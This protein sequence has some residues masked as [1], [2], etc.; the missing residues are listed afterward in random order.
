[1][2]DCRALCRSPECISM[3]ALVGAAHCLPS[4][5]CY[6]AITITNSNIKTT[7]LPPPPP[8]PNTLKIISL[9]RNVQ[10]SNT[11]GIRENLSCSCKNSSDYDK[12]YQDIFLH[13]DSSPS[14]GLH[15]LCVLQSNLCSKG[16]YLY[17]YRLSPLLS[18]SLLS[19]A[20]LNQ[21]IAGRL[22][23]SPVE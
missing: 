22:P 17:Y 2:S 18:C 5:C 19:P 20:C 1:M 13:R 16:S 8:P 6:S 10:R 14:G 9:F 11:M 3:P 12:S 21:L 15:W 23:W 4:S 7:S